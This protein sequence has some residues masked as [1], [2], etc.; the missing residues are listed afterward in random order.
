MFYKV[1]GRKGARREILAPLLPGEYMDKDGLVLRERR[2]G[3]QVSGSNSLSRASPGGHLG[4]Q[5]LTRGRRPSTS[6]SQE[7]WTPVGKRKGRG[8]RGSPE[9]DQDKRFR[10]GEWDWKQ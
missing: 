4:S 3:R 8:S 7:T 1:V 5:V 9:M 6:T 2:E 10:E